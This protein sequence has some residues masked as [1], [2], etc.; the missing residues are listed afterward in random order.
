[1]KRIALLLA[2]ASLVQPSGAIAADGLKPG[3]M[4]KGEHRRLALHF[5][6]RDDV[7]ELF[8]PPA[9]EVD[10]KP[11]KINK[12]LFTDKQDAM[13]ACLP[14]GSEAH[15]L[16]KYETVGMDDGKY[17]SDG[18]AY[19]AFHTDGRVCYAFATNVDF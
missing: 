14:A 19:I 3:Q 16:W 15:Q 12:W 18:Y 11:K 17:K 1:M 7:L 9:D 5:S 13:A 6:T 8:G 10:A 2:L 4:G